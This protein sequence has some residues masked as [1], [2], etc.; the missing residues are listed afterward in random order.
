MT[1]APTIGELVPGWVYEGKFPEGDEAALAQLA[2]AW[3]KQAESNTTHAEELLHAME[4][5]S[6]TYSGPA[7]RAANQ[8]AEK[9]RTWLESGAEGCTSLSEACTAAS[10]LITA[11]K[12]AMN[13][14]LLSL[15]VSTQ[16]ILKAEGGNILDVAGKLIKIRQVQIAAQA[17]IDALSRALVTKLGE[18][19]PEVEIKPELPKPKS[20]LLPGLG[21]NPAHP[22][23]YADDTDGSKVGGDVPME[24]GFPDISDIVGA[25]DATSAMD[26]NGTTPGMSPGVGT[27]GQ[28]PEGL[29]NASDSALSD[30]EREGMYEEALTNLDEGDTTDYTEPNLTEDAEQVDPDAIPDSGYDTAPGSDTSPTNPDGMTPEQ[31]LGEDPTER[32]EPI[33]PSDEFEGGGPGPGTED[34]PPAPIYDAPPLPEDQGNGS[35]G[36]GSDHGGADETPSGNDP[37]PS[38]P[39]PIDP[40][41]GNNQNPWSPPPPQPEAPTYTPPVDHG[42]GNSGGNDSGGSHHTPPPPTYGPPPPIES[43]PVAP[44]EE[45][46]TSGAGVAPTAPIGNPGGPTTAP[47][48]G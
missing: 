12:I 5:L 15:Q 44:P 33:I 41:P 43:Q 3:S 7:A 32:P 46:G 4:A 8:S 11:T 30:E 23:G 31:I 24:D 36:N 45:P 39:T 10:V 16:K 29:Q 34:G 40:T 19:K 37:T 42:G 28:G 18:L 13:V 48:P 21:D 20:L 27:P 22:I 38:R 14:V 2:R 17:Q 25:D 47:P 9:T 6:E 26:E 35:D 1:I